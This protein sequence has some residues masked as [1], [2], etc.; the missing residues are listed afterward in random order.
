M[1]TTG[2]IQPLNPKPFLNNLTGKPIICKLKW[3]MEY[4]GK[5][6]AILDLIH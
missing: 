3:G 2:M 5:L 4:R 6:G 1:S